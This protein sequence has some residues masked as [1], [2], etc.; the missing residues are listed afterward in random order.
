MAEFWGWVT[1]MTRKIR[2]L[3][4]ASSKTMRNDAKKSP[5][6]MKLRPYE[7]KAIAGISSRLR[8]HK[9]LLA[10]APTGAGKTV[11]GAAYVL[12]EPKSQVLWLAHRKELLDQALAQLK[13][14]GIPANDL[15]LL[16]GARKENVDARVLVAGVGM[17]RS[18]DVGERD[19]VVIDEAHHAS[20]GGYASILEAVPDANVLGF[21]A[22]PWRLD[23][24]PLGEHFDDLYV[25]AEADE[26]IVDGYL[27]RSRV[28]GIPKEKAKDLVK[29]LA[30]GG[31]GDWSGAAVERAMRKR[32]LTADIVKEWLR[33]AN[34][35]ST[36]VY[37]S[38]LAH[39][40]DLLERFRRARVNAALLTWAT[41]TAE[42]DAILE[43][44]KSG[45]I[46]VLVNVGILTEGFDCPDAK[47]IVIARPTKSL[48]LYRQMCGRGARP[49]SKRYL[50]LDETGNVWRHGFPEAPIEWSLTEPVRGGG[51]APVKQCAADGCTC[52]MPIS[53]MVC[54]ECGEEQPEP[55][56]LVAQRRAQLEEIRAAAA[57][58]ARREKVIR[59]IAKS[60]G[61]SN[62]ETAHALQVLT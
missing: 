4:R 60:R 28:F 19:L 9:R 32:Q 26:L 41:P 30:T 37:A 2:A 6:E 5:F 45:A 20:A 35:L 47:C 58:K 39:A 57:E 13:R 34:G 61:W 31:N 53:V 50:V 1:P 11:I 22:T 43:G 42:R 59:E 10:V 36:I 21:T 25:M 52:V 49:H 18:R 33:L 16:S 29:G 40:A 38:G 24:Q 14:A 17:F 8:K 48:T 27:A 15:G 3:S 54:P 44:F 55:E 46:T 23:G 12:S 56:E 51:A 7:V 62:K